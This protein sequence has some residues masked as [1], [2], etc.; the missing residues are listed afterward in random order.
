MLARIKLWWAE[1]ST[2][3]NQAEVARADEAADMSDLLAKV[4]KFRAEVRKFHDVT[5][6]LH[7]SIP[8]K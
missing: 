7:Q 2:V 3:P 5:S 6:E 1:R 4:I 8:N